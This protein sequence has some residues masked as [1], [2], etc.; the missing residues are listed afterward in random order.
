MSDTSYPTVSQANKLID[1]IDDE[2]R[3]DYISDD[4]MT[5]A[6]TLMF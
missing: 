1:V 4:G 2:W 5:N 6:V 3:I